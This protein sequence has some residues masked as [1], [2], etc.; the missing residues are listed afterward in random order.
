MAPRMINI[1][2]LCFLSAK[3]FSIN[4][5][6]PKSVQEELYKRALQHRFLGSTPD[7]QN[8]YLSGEG[9]NDSDVQCTGESPEPDHIQSFQVKSR[10]ESTFIE[11]LRYAQCSGRGFHLKDTFV[12]NSFQFTWM[13]LG[14]DGLE[15]S[16]DTIDRHIFSPLYH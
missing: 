13:G 8:C 9:P 7:V 12:H 11:N 15:K 10:R 3:H 1:S 16:Y 6:V 4:A 5:L 2:Q 14:E